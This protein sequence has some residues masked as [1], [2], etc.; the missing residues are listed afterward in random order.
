MNEPIKNFPYNKK[1]NFQT[2]Y[3]TLRFF[4]IFF[5]FFTDK[6]LKKYP[7]K[8]HLNKENSIRKRLMIEKGML[9]N[10]NS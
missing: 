2:S 3:E 1:K 9:K 5:N 7:Y 10:R 6:S 4:Y 8:K